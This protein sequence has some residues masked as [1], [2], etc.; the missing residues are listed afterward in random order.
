MQLLYWLGGDTTLMLLGSE[1]WFLIIVALQWMDREQVVNNRRYCLHF[2][3]VS[4]L[5]R[6]AEDA[7]SSST[8]SICTAS[9]GRSDEPDKYSSRALVHLT[10]LLFMDVEWLFLKSIFLLAPLK[11]LKEHEKSREDPASSPG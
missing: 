3:S 7:A 1:M 9:S 6:S 11:S 10:L 2:V 5:L 8:N 4:S